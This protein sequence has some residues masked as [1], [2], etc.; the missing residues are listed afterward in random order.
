MDPTV[1]IGHT[2]MVVVFVAY[3]LWFISK[4]VRDPW[5]GPTIADELRP[6]ESHRDMYERL[7]KR[8]Y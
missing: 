8:S 5:H 7:S 2:L 4:I 3:A 1:V 6:G